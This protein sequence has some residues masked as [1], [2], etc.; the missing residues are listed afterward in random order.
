MYYEGIKIFVKNIVCIIN[1]FIF[2]KIIA[3]IVKKKD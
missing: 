2:V 1:K 3:L